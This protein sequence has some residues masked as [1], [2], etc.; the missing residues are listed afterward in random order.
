MRKIWL[1]TLMAGSLLSSACAGKIPADKT[2]D[3]TPM[4]SIANVNATGVKE[5]GREISQSGD[6]GEA[7]GLTES[8]TSSYYEGQSARAFQMLQKS[9]FKNLLSGWLGEDIV[10]P[11]WNYD[12]FTRYDI[13]D[14]NFTS[15][16]EWQ[17]LYYC[18][19]SSDNDKT[20]Y[21]VLAYHGD[22]MSKVDA[23]VTPYLYDLEANIEDI[24]TQLDQSEID[25]TTASARRVRLNGTA[26]SGSREAILVEDKEHIFS[27]FFNENSATLDKGDAGEAVEQSSLG[28]D[29]KAM[30]EAQSYYVGFISKA[31]NDSYLLSGTVYQ[32]EE[33]RG[34][35]RVEAP[36]GITI[37]VR[38]NLKRVEGDIELIFEG[39]DG[40][41]KVLAT[42]GEDTGEELA[43]DASVLVE[44]GVGNIYFEGTDAIYQFDLSLDYSGDI[45][46][47]LTGSNP[48]P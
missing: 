35:V 12:S 21:V 10:N 24:G 39:V 7:A 2:T 41:K 25:M 45:R 46:Y 15:T 31:N 43:V 40:N 29:I 3:L 47:Y 28:Q 37:S 13:L 19:F 5:D 32:N 34:L 48:I 44:K 9:I 17:E 11:I 30:S 18:T 8:V 16:G 33:K 20:G 6:K 23:A 42:S 26:N 14:E 1:V 38:G 27:Y 22:S 4:T 36:D